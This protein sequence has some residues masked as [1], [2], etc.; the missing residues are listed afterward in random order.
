MAF[1]SLQIGM[2]EKGS[3]IQFSYFDKKI[4]IC[5]IYLF[6]LKNIVRLIRITL[7]SEFRARRVHCLITRKQKNGPSCIIFEQPFLHTHTL[8]EFVEL[9]EFCTVLILFCMTSMPRAILMPHQFHHLPS[10]KPFQKTRSL[11]S[12]VSALPI[13]ELHRTK[14]CD[15][16]DFCPC[17]TIHTSDILHF[18][19]CFKRFGAVFK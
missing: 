8:L 19:G 7:F 2:K 11:R 9:V 18:V 1:L 12:Q 16:F 10:P 13:K 15:Q 14:H 17:T 3:N 5:T 6:V 4:V